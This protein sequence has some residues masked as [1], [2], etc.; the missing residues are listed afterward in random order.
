MNKG[1][2]A[3]PRFQVQDVEVCEN[4]D[5]LLNGRLDGGS[6]SDGPRWFWLWLTDDRAVKPTV[7]ER[8]DSLV[9][10]LSAEENPGQINAGDSYPCHDAYWDLHQIR[11]IMKGEWHLQQFVPRDAT[12]F[13]LHGVTGWG[14][15]EAGVPEGAEVKDVL[16]GGWDHE[17]CEICGAKIGRGG[18]ASG[19]VDPEGH[20]LCPTCHDRWAQEQDLGFVRGP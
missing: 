6:L 5:V 9:V 15:V 13:E 18:I 14:P 4:G 19:Y 17:H 2:G 10:R 12:L 11:M 1:L 16:P 8:G 7:E 20:W 3:L